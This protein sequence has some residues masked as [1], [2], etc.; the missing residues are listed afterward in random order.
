MLLNKKFGHCVYINPFSSEKITKCFQF[1]MFGVKVIQIL[2]TNYFDIAGMKV[3]L[4]RINVENVLVLIN[5]AQFV[6]PN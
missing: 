4:F 1:V 5:E 2:S 3:I 6:H